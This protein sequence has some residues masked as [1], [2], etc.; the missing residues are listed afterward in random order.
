MLMILINNYNEL[1]KEMVFYILFNAL[2]GYV[3]TASTSQ[4]MK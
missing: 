2:L 3:G 1:M 4:G